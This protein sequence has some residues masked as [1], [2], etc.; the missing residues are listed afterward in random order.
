MFAPAVHYVAVKKPDG[1]DGIGSCF[2]VGG[3]VFVTAK[4]VLEH[5]SVVSVGRESG[6][7]DGAGNTYASSQVAQISLDPEGV[8]VAVFVVDSKSLPPKVTLD[9]TVDEGVYWLDELLLLGFPPIPLSSEPVLVAASSEINSGVTTYLPGSPHPLLV[10]SAMARAGFSGGVA[11]HLKKTAA[12][13]VITESL[14]KNDEPPELGFFA[15]VP[16]A[17]ILS[18]LDHA[19][20][21][22]HIQH[23]PGT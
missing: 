17:S 15:V 11:V 4:H 20:L 16:A 13:G 8:D 18:C 7:P 2:H 6:W 5:N 14:V 22:S 1:S 3:G 23:P 9:A 21:S 12:L 19:G 10:V